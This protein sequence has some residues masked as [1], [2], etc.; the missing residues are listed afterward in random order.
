VTSESKRS[1]NR[2]NS[3]ASTGPKSP[4]GRAASARNAFRHGLSVPVKHDLTLFGEIEA[5]A[6]EIAG[7]DSNAEIQE[8]ARRVAEAQFD[9]HRA[10]RARHQ[11]LSQGLSDRSRTDAQERAG[12]GL[13]LPHCNAAK[14]LLQRLR[15][16]DTAVRQVAASILSDQAKELLAIDRYERR[17]LSRRK[18]AIL[19]LDEAVSAAATSVRR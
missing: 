9:L 11:L 16:C 17:A 7:A 15:N 8:S 6:Y 13:S 2:T 12:G 19:A 1:A 18:S 14:L 4:R 10:R 5:L 3:H